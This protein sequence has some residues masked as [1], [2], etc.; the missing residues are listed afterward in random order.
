MS[1]P[2]S[3]GM[4]H[5]P[6]VVAG[7]PRPP[8]G[9]ALVAWAVIIIVALLIILLNIAGE[10]TD[11]GK[12]IQAAADHV[13]DRMEGRL[14]V[15]MNAVGW[16]GSATTGLQK[17][18]VGSPEHRFR[19]VVL[20]GELEGADAAR[21]LLMRMEVQMSEAGYVP[22][23]QQD[24]IFH[25]L[26]RIY[27]AS[28]VPGEVPGGLDAGEQETLIDS[29][30]WFGELALHPAGSGES[31][32][33]RRMQ[34]EAVVV[35]VA[36][37]V[38]GSAFMGGLVIGLILLILVIVLACSRR[39]YHGL[40]PSSNRDGLLAEAFAVW[41]VVFFLVQYGLHLL[42]ELVPALSGNALLL[43][44]IVQ[45]STVLIVFWPVLRGNT[46]A[47]TRRAIGWT[48]GPEGSG[49]LW[50]E[51]GWGVCGYLMML[52]LLAIGVLLVYLLMLVT[53]PDNPGTDFSPAPMPSH[54]I[55]LMVADGSI[56]AIV[57]VYFV[58]AIVAP[59]LEETLFRGVLY[60]Q[61]RT[62]TGGWRIGW[63]VV[64]SILVVSLVFAAI[65]PQGLLGIPALAAIAVGLALMREWR[66]SLI[67]P[68]V[69]HGCSNGIVITLMVLAAR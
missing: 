2:M 13:T 52:P 14:L 44:G 54:P 34:N 11:G 4:E 30:G 67:A 38:M 8:M 50:R 29:L 66:G 9:F 1:E 31:E 16:G 49:S 27:D 63:S 21:A 35:L 56:W 33:R 55:L 59:F 28:P 69:M 48:T 62:A 39:L 25:D 42:V 43:A 18:E 58:A 53:A 36:L 45:G 61:L 23:S 20:A 47:Q 41:M 24:R 65:H 10:S 7:D 26:S 40:G 17:F 32:L 64:I 60:R 46:W 22:T 5:E 51:L 19:G 15:G 57:Q 6:P 12:D 3:P 37:A 68:M